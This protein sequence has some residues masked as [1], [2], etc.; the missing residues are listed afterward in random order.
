[1]LDRNIILGMGTSV[2]GASKLT[3]QSTLPE[4]GRLRVTN[5]YRKRLTKDYVSGHLKLYLEM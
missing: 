4:M 1:M 3:C 2:W 5:T